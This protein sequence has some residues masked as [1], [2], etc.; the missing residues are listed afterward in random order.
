M[1]IA[2]I[3]ILAFIAALASLYFEQKS[4]IDELERI[5]DVE[6]VKKKTRTVKKEEPFIDG[7]VIDGNKT[8][9]DDQHVE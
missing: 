6:P 9:E 3:A 2:A 8:N 5:D 7:T 1:V 4:I